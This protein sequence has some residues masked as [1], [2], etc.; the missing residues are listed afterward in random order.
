MIVLKG[1]RKTNN[2]IP[3][4]NVPMPRTK[5]QRVPVSIFSHE[6][7]ELFNKLVQSTTWVRLK[8]FR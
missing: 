8:Y 4:H 7:I 6:Y 3:K 5:S 1:I 2:D